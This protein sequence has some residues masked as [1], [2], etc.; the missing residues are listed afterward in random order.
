MQAHSSH[1]RDQLSGRGG[2][3][4]CHLTCQ[5]GLRG[6]DRPHRAATR[7]P[8][9]LLLDTD[10][11]RDERLIAVEVAAAGAP[12][13]LNETVIDL[14]DVRG[15]TGELILNVGGG[16]H[17]QSSSRH[18]SRRER[19]TAE[20]D[21]KHPHKK[22]AG[23]SGWRAT[24]VPVSISR[25]VTRTIWVRAACCSRRHNARMRTSTSEACT[26]R[27]QSY[28]LRAEHSQRAVGIANGVCT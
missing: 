6:H 15:G 9:Q 17:L 23:F 4:G 26:A 25:Q 18:E 11:A 10:N 22:T 12:A 13:R 14:G 20:A 7:L 5:V 19:N 24:A 8:G 28:R 21:M 27:A 2:V 3:R 16:C 1:L